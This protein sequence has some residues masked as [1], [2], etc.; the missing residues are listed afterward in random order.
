M[1]TPIIVLTGF[2]GSGKTTLMQH[3][4]DQF[5]EK[6]GKKVAILVNDFGEIPVDA[7]LLSGGELESEMLYEV[8][9]GS[10]FCACL[11]D[12][13]ILGLKA[14]LDIEPDLILVEASGMADPSGIS[15]MLRQAGLTDQCQLMCTLCVFDAIKSLKLAANLDTIPRQV[16]GAHYVLL[17]KADLATEAQ[18]GEAKAYIQ[19]TNPGVTLMET[20]KCRFEVS[21]LAQQMENPFALMPSL[22]TPEN[23]PDTFTVEAITGSVADFA[24]TLEAQE[25]LLRVKGCLVEDGKPVY[26]SDTGA[27]IEITPCE[28]AFSPVVV[29]TMQGQ[30][31]SV[32]A[33]LEGQG[34]I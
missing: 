1:K 23:R 19:G 30:G 8:S 10:I 13:F 11:K 17:N 6:N 31:E 28:T 27:G 24:K 5:R 12:N 2:L 25:E 33:R 26:I 20:V 21:E 14:L 32:K 16:K 29:I 34:L 7:T 3:L 18:L 22:N 15:P 9:G 4:M